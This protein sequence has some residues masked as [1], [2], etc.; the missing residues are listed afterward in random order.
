[1]YRVKRT[2]TEIDDC[3]NWATEAVDEGRT[4]YGGVTFE[5]G[6]QQGIDWVLG[7]IDD[8]PHQDE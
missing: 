4:N 2:D 7:N 3:L 8:A 5:Q 1:M 6:V